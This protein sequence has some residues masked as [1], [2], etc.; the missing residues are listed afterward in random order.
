MKKV[1]LV[2]ATLLCSLSIEAQ[3][4]EQIDKYSTGYING[5]FMNKYKSI[6][7]V[8]Y[9]IGYETTQD[10]ILVRYPAGCRNTTY[11][12]HPNCRRIA[13]GAFQ[14]A[15]YLKVIYL[16]ES[17]SYIGEDAFADCTSLQG[18]YYG[19]EATQVKNVETTEEKNDA[20]IMA[21]YNL[22][23]LPCSPS[24]KG[25]QIIVYPDYTTKTI[26]VE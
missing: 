1:L 8:L 10:W 19:D 14:G 11:T 3:E 26:I 13:R 12:V 16:P 18:I 6:D 24:D 25:V 15:S 2:I 21:R 17:V 22:A 7:G 4:I 20:E 9:A 5:A 23:G